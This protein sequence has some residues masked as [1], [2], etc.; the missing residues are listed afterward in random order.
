MRKRTPQ[1]CVVLVVYVDDII[2]IGN[3]EAEV[4][5]IK[6]YLRQHFVMRDLS[7]PRYFLGLEIAYKR[8][9]MVLC[10]QKYTLDL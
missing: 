3:D 2:L 1:G 9:Q 7:L 4:A 8:D 5:S 6:V 10:Q